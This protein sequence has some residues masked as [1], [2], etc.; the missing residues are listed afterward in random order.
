MTE[1]EESN[2]EVFT[3][4]KSGAGYL[5]EAALE[6]YTTISQDLSVQAYEVSTEYLVD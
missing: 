6:N 1:T 5:N 2:E 3:N 4:D